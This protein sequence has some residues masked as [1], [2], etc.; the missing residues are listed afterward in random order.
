MCLYMGDPF[1]LKGHDSH[2][3]FVEP[4]YFRKGA[5]KWGGKPTW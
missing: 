4:E 5:G 3:P 2:M 1:G